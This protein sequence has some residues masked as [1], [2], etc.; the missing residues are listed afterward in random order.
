MIWTLA[1]IATSIFTIPSTSHIL[2]R[3]DTLTR[4]PRHLAGTKIPRPSTS[5]YHKTVEASILVRSLFAGPRGPT[6]Y[7]TSGGIRFYTSKNIWNGSTGIKAPLS[8]CTRA[9]HGCAT[10]LAFSPN[11]IS[12]RSLQAHVARNPT[13]GSTTRRTRVT[14]WSIWLGASMAGTVG[15]R[16]SSTASSAKSSTGLGGRGGQAHLAPRGERTLR[17]KAVDQGGMTLR[18]LEPLRLLMLFYYIPS[19]CIRRCA[20]TRDLRADSFVH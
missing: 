6:A 13:R 2:P 3:Q 17:R 18:L 15:A 11:D 9:N 19:G 14:L 8:T 7:W 20:G 5:F 1:S 16:W 4:Y 12:T 10:A